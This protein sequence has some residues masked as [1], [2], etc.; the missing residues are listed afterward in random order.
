MGNPNDYDPEVACDYPGGS[1]SHVRLA[2]GKTR[3]QPSMVVMILLTDG[4]WTLRNINNGITTPNAGDGNCDSGHPHADVKFQ[5]GGDTTGYNLPSGLCAGTWNGSSC[6]TAPGTA[7][8]STTC[9][10]QSVLLGEIIRYRIRN[11]LDG[12][13]NLERFSSGL[14][15]NFNAGS[16]PQFQVI[17][18][19]IEDLQVRYTAANSTVTDN[20]GV[21]DRTGLDYNTIIAERHRH[22]VGAQRGAERDGRACGPPWGRPRCAARSP[23]SAA[24]GPR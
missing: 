7:C 18:R 6:D 21:V 19:G 12:V 5:N 20:A 23:R 3:V 2:A 10:V 4:T 15:A 13:P 8:L 9:K 22:P 1:S 24:R 11:G 16:V 17:A 14:S